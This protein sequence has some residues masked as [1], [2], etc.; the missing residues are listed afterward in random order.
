MN[1]INKIKK[2][3]MNCFLKMENL[4]G[5]VDCPNKEI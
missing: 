5:L 1:M 4:R 3:I 2:I